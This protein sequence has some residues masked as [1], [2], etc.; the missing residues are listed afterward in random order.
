MRLA[1]LGKRGKRNA[2]V[3][4]RLPSI[5]GARLNPLPRNALTASAPSGRASSALPSLNTIRTWVAPC[6]PHSDSRLLI[7]RRRPLRRRTSR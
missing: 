5:I 6:S 3:T 7:T 1:E 2:S 4:P